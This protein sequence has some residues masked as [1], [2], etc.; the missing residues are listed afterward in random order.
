MKP[1]SCVLAG[2]ALLGWAGS[3]GAQDRAAWMQN[4]RW[5]VMTH[6]LADW[7]ARV[8]NLTMSVDEW[9]RLVDGFDTEGIARQL[10]SAGAK[11]YQISIG[12]N[13][14][15]YLSPNATY[16][17]LVGITPSKC[18]RRDLIADLYEALHKR[19][20]KLMVYLPSGAP[21]QDRV[22]D[23]A[24]GW[25]NGPNPNKDFQR[26]WEQVIREWSERWGKK[27]SGWWFD[28]C[29]FPNTMY[30]SPEPPNFMSFAAAARAGNPDAIVAFNPGVVYRMLSVTPYE[31]FT[32]GEIDKP[33]LVTI[34]RAAGGKVDGTQIHM[35]SF[36]GETWGRGTPRFTAEQLIGY[37]KKV[38]DAGGA[39]TW[40]IPVELN[41]TISQPFLD[42]LAA[43]RKAL[44]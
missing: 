22:A 4:A 7:Q 10:E 41:G 18:S 13:S 3:A 33:E 16:D 37:T 36:L 28:G 32:A 35:L 26:K 44:Q 42:Q 34:R 9:N 20:I 43:L 15:Y 25:S 5:G 27:V 29:Y 30:R 1:V 17:R 31:D 24:L 38:L 8:H 40:D 23:A 39:V 2:L 21:G 12:Q 19:G 11:Y 6:Y 14:G